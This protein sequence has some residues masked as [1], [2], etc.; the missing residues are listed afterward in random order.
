MAWSPQSQSITD[1]DREGNKKAA[2]I[3]RRAEDLLLKILKMDIH[4]R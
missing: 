4:A 2:N 3:Q 1:R